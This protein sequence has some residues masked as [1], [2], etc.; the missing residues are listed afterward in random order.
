MTR[1]PQGGNFRFPSCSSRCLQW[2]PL[3]SECWRARSANRDRAGLPP[4][5]REQPSPR[6]NFTGHPRLT[7]RKLTVSA[8]LR[9]SGE[10]KR[11]GA[12]STTRPLFLAPH[13]CSIC[14]N[15]AP[16][17]RT[18]IDSDIAM[19]FRLTPPGPLIFFVSLI[20]AVLAVATSLHPCSGRRTL[21]RHA[22]FLGDDGGVCGVACGR[23]SSTGFSKASA[24][25]SWR[26]AGTLS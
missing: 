7:R 1:R 18:F 4:S 3:R 11:K 5:R 8:P 26:Q 9:S 13:P 24:R 2:Q 14:R 20:L 12:A 6:G 16:R 25:A 23:A 19:R 10:F 21:C 22:S 15:E 17:L